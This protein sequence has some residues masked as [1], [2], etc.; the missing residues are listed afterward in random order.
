MRQLSVANGRAALSIR[1]DA[2]L[3]LQWMGDLEVREEDALSVIE[4]IQTMSPRCEYPLL[5]DI[6]QLGQISPGARAWMATAR[7]SKV[8]LLGAT[9]VDRVIAN[10]FIAVN[11]PSHPTRFFLSESEA[12]QWL[13]QN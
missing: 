1:T 2:I 3:L 13:K 5:A 11:Q 12:V 7:A 10:F 8:A 6:T 9:P 4:A